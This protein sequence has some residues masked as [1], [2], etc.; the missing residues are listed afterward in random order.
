[1]KIDYSLSIPLGPF[2]ETGL[3]D[4]FVDALY[5]TYTIIDQLDPPQYIGNLCKRFTWLKVGN[6]M[7]SSK[8]ARSDRAIFAPIGSPMMDHQLVP[9]QI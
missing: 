9:T 7:Y 6:H 8:L 4:S 2:S 5:T 1:M 3:N